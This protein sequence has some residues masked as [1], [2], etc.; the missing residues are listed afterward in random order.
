MDALKKLFPFTAKAND[1]TSLVIAIVIYVVIGAIIGVI[2]SIVGK[3][4]F[5]GIICGIV[6]ALAEIY[7]LGGI[8]LSVL[9][10]LEIKI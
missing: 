3:I 10:F 4:P 6:G 1:V 7:C 8:I 5:A 9:D 2:L